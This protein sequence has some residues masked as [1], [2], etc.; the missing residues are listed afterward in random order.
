MG[1]LLMLEYRLPAEFSWIF[2]KFDDEIDRV[3]FQELFI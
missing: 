1:H 3:I 2:Q